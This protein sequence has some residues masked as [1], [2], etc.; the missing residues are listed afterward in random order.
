M[1]DKLKK[2]IG[3]LPKENGF[4][5]RM[6]FHQAWWRTFVLAEESG[7]HP[8]RKK[9]TIGSAILSGDETNKNFLTQKIISVVEE[10]IHGRR[11]ENSGLLEEDRLFNN[12]L[13][14]Q[15]L[16][17]N[18]FGELK[19]DL[20]LAQKLL[21][22]F[23]PGITKVTGVKFEFAPTRKYTNDNSAFDIAFDV[24]AGEKRGLVGIECKYTDTFS[25]K[26]YSK[27]EYHQIYSKGGERIFAAPYEDFIAARFNQLFRNQLV[28]ESLVQNEEYDFVLTGLFCH[29]DDV[30]ARET[31]AIFQGMLKDGAS[32]FRVI[33]YQEYLENIQQFDL[34]WEQRELS[35]LLW[36][37][38]C[39]LPLSEELSK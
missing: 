38:Y 17:F 8:V 6:R 9:E 10:T 20:A 7:I 18:F 24:M 12:L 27:E 15:P 25:Q 13:S 39:G 31:A 35:M 26:E 37:R 28:G 23:Y 3:N 1:K 5:K 29:Q 22:R 21:R 34:T 19:L 4:K 14:S 36:A 33:T 30:N 11:V 16:C 2:L 32:K